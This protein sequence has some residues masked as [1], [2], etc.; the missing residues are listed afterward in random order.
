MDT[1]IKLQ[2]YRKAYRKIVIKDQKSGFFAHGFFYLIVNTGLIVLNLS[3]MPQYKWFY[4]PLLSWG[5]GLAMHYLFGIVL[6]NK[7]LKRNET[8][9]EKQARESAKS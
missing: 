2:D 3:M 8:R 5:F 1:N 4:W 7:F 9:A 6:I